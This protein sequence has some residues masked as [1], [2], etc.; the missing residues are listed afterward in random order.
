MC[1][2]CVFHCTLP[3]LALAP[4]LCHAALATASPRTAF[5]WIAL[6]STVDAESDH[7]PLLTKSMICASHP[8][9]SRVSSRSLMS[10]SV[11]FLELY[12]FYSKNATTSLVAIVYSVYPTRDVLLSR[13]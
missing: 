8:S 12:I 9:S 2:C 6:F 5:Q 13:V 10:V 3:A 4:L 11:F 7:K 1:L